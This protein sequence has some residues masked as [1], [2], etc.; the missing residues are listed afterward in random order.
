MWKHCSP[1]VF[2]LHS[3][4]ADALNAHISA[5]SATYSAN[6]LTFFSSLL[7][8][9]L[10]PYLSPSPVLSLSVLEKHWKSTAVDSCIIFSQSELSRSTRRSNS[11]HSVQY[12]PHN[13]QLEHAYL[14][15]LFFSSYL[16]LSPARMPVYYMWQA[17]LQT[18]D[19]HRH[20]RGSPG[21]CGQLSHSYLLRSSSQS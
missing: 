14:L 1:A 17:A 4:T 21:A 13:K 16:V 12:L 2:P 18:A 11:E 20:S 9:S 3:N 6:P 15:S 7:S 8:N 5:H 19:L 10:S